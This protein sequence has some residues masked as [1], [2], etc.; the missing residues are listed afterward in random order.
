MR[1]RICVALALTAIQLVAATSAVACSCMGPP[2][3]AEALAKVDIVLTCRVLRAAVPPPH[4]LSDSDTTRVISSGDMVRYVL[5]PLAVWKGAVS[6]T[7]VVYSA[8][9]SISCGYEMVPGNEYLLFIRA[10]REFAR[11][12]ERDL[13]I[14]W[15]GGK[16][17]GA[18]WEVGLCDRNKPVEKAADDLAELGRALWLREER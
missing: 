13:G 8:R 3:V 4:P 5:Q 1:I 7:I 17:N 14:V 18:I 16:P 9:S 12:G 6:D 15:A 11:R 10:H 2:P